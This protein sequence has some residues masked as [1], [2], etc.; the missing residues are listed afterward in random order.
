MNEIACIPEEIEI[1]DDT[2]GK[3]VRSA[4]A[5]LMNKAKSDH[6]KKIDAENKKDRLDDFDEK[7]HLKITE[8]LRD[9]FMRTKAQEIVPEIVELITRVAKRGH[10]KI[11]YPALVMM[12]AEVELL[13]EIRDHQVIVYFVKEFVKYGI[14]RRTGFEF[15][16]SSYNSYSGRYDDGPQVYRYNISV[17]W[18]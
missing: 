1:A 17:E 10:N 11:I 14:T 13:G 5:A 3:S 6:R 18:K 2:V 4:L 15:D 7:I 8:K 12:P 9:R 16:C